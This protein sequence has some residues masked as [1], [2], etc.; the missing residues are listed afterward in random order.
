MNNLVKQA[1][2]NAVSKGFYDGIE[3]FRSLPADQ[4]QLHIS[5]KLM[6]IVSEASEAFE[7][8]RKMEFPINPKLPHDEY[9]ERMGYEFDAG[10][11][12]HFIKDTLADE[13]ADIIIRVFDLAGWLGIDLD[14]HVKLKM[15]YNSTREKKHGKNF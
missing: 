12:K 13:C 11:F 6:L 15:M 3:D 14:Q 10:T 2:G 7:A 5:Q 4:Q 1:H 9:Y 8:L